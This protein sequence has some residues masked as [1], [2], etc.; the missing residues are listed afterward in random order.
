MQAIKFPG[1]RGC[2]VDVL[3]A[4]SVV[5]HGFHVVVL[6]AYNAVDH[7]CHVACVAAASVAYH[8]FQVREIYTFKKWFIIVS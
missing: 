3:A 4:C 5:D 6:A 7:G 1:F 2:C 8:S